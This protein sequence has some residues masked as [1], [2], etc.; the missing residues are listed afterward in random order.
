MSDIL[1]RLLDRGVTQFHVASECADVL[2]TAGYSR[3]DMGASWSLRAGGRYFITPY[4]SMLVAFSIPR[5]AGFS[6][7]REEL[8]MN[9]GLAHTDFPMLKLK[10]SA[11]M[12]RE[13]YRTLNVEPYGGLLKDTWFDRPLGIAGRLVLET[14]DPFAPKTVMYR[15]DKALCVIPSLAPHLISGDG[16]EKMDVQ[17]ELIPVCALTG[18]MNGGGI[19]ELVAAKAGVLPDEILDYDLYLYNMDRPALLG[20]GGDL[21]SSPRIDN[22]SSVA[23]LTDV[24]CRV[25]TGLD[26]MHSINLISLFDNEEIGSRSKQGADSVLLSDIISRLCDE[27]ELT[28]AQR[29]GLMKRS[30]MLS[31]DVAHAVH[32]NYPEKSD[33]TNKVVMGKGVA[34]KTS[35]GQRYVSDSEAAAVIISLA[36]RHGIAVQRQVNRSGMPGGQTLGPIAS[37]YLPVKAVDMGIPVLAMHSARELCCIDDYRQLVEVCRRVF[38]TSCC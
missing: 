9:I 32:P 33:P 12:D 6:N 20:A 27:L 16:K 5:C 35:A 1:L 26:G 10:S 38:G 15:S 24:M 30:F 14:D 18:D 19:L 17:K 2:E 34:L 7:G 22:V 3:L 25:D 29:A 23:A 37:S 21:I 36:R 13:G 4:P 31:L 28:A 8:C 11:D